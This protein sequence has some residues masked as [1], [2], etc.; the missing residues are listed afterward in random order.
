MPGNQSTH[1]GGNLLV[2]HVGALP[3]HRSVV[4]LL[5]PTARALDLPL[6]HSQPKVT[7]HLARSESVLRRRM[8]RAFVHILRRVVRAALAARGWVRLTVKACALCAAR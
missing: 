6:P 5:G 1:R 2:S 3:C 7:D 8:A 4:A